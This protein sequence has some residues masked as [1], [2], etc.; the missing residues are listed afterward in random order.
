MASIGPLA[1]WCRRVA[2]PAWEVKAVVPPGASPHA[3]EVLP[4][5]VQGFE[6][7]SL[8]LR[9][10]AGLDPFVD[11]LLAAERP[12]CVVT[13]TDGVRLR[14]GN[15]HVWLDPVVARAMLPRIA[16]ALATVDPADSAGYHARARDYAAS[17]DSLDSEYR[18]AAAGF[19]VRRFVAF[20]EAWTYLAARYGLEQAGSLEPAPG[21]E[22]GPTDWAR[23]VGLV[24]SSGSRVVFAEPQFGR[25]LPAALAS[26][27]GVRVLMLDPMGTTGEARGESYVALMRRNLAVLREGL[28]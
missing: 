13:A 12:R 17:L 2:G 27:A 11:R 22:P 25:R 5:D 8:W 19:R 18:A 24:K 14:E 26:D 21:R 16:E 4:R 15:P 3:F 10:G 1:D 23:L 7:A 6:S 9:V 28:K 20:H